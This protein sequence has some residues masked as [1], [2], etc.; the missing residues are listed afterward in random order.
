MAETGSSF[1]QTSETTA[2][3]IS[4]LHPFYTYTLTVAAVTI[5]PGPYGLALTVQM[6][7]DGMDSSNSHFTFYITYPY[8]ICIF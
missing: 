4:N 3:Y 1:Q 8:D 5:G 6:T 7:E 2:L